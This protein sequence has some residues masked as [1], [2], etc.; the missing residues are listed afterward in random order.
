MVTPLSLA[1]DANHHRCIAA[2]VGTSTAEAEATVNTASFDAVMALPHLQGGICETDVFGRAQH[3][4]R[5]A[6]SSGGLDETPRTRTILQGPPLPS[7][8]PPPPPSES[9]WGAAWRAIRDEADSVAKCTLV[10]YLASGS[11][12]RDRPLVAQH[13]STFDE[14]AGM[15]LAHLAASKR[16]KYCLLLLEKALA[17]EQS[18]PVGTD[19]NQNTP[20][21]LLANAEA[22]A[23]A[24]TSAA[25]A[26]AAREPE[27]VQ[28]AE[29]QADELRSLAEAAK[30]SRLEYQAL[31]GGTLKQQ[32]AEQRA[33]SV[34]DKT[35]ARRYAGK[36]PCVDVYPKRGAHPQS[37]DCPCARVG[38]KAKAVPPAE[39]GTAASP[40]PLTHPLSYPR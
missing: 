29:Q 36:S 3:Y 32:V 9:S 22:V 40:H 15:T 16:K 37:P 27:A 31:F 19:L 33:R 6:P 8:V 12:G 34:A 1:T 4:A 18:A 25:G 28:L 2:L 5:N 26:Q 38:S 13:L 21:E 20:R 39:T 17:D 23:P 11:Q 35:E 14:H 7:D 30:G 24:L 10:K